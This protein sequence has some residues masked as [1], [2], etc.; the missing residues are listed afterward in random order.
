MYGHNDA[1]EKYIL[2]VVALYSL[3]NNIACVNKLKLPEFY[4][5]TSAAVVVLALTQSQRQWQTSK[6]L[7]MLLL[8]PRR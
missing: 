7:K 4:S 3:G 2:L 5:I 8:R 1:V 6:S